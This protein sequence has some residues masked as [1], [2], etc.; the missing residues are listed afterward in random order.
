VADKRARM[1]DFLWKHSAL[2]QWAVRPYE[3]ALQQKLDEIRT[4]NEH[5]EM[6]NLV[7]R[8]TRETQIAFVEQLKTETYERER[9]GRASL[10]TLKNESR[11]LFE[12]LH[13][14]EETIRW[15]KYFGHWPEQSPLTMDPG[16][17]SRVG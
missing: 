5:I 14:A 8:E 4:L 2:Y 16:M 13:E 11:D 15:A 10:E 7:L 6:Q 1:R 17:G 9:I 3:A 12:R